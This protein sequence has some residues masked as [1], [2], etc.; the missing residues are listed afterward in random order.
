MSYSF[1]IQAPNK[2]AAKEAVALKFD[3]VI[4]LQPIHTRDRAAVLANAGAVI[5]LLA[6][7][8]TKDI[9]VS[10][11]GY[12]S[13]PGGDVEHLSSVNIGCYASHIARA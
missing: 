7:D 4:T 5:D 3:D 2:A 8:D 11:S 12:V 1:Q 13:W 9:T 10:C 6:D